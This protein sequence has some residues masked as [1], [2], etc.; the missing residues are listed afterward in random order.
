MGW[1]TDPVHNPFRRGHL[2]LEVD[3]DLNNFFALEIAVKI[4][5]NPNREMLVLDHELVK[6]RFFDKRRSEEVVNSKTIYKLD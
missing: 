1:D 2:L 5:R 4:A 3:L 6:A